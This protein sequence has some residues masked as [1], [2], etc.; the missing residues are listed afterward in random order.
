[1]MW[2][3]ASYWLIKAGKQ[4]SITLDETGRS[5]L[6]DC[7]YIVHMGHVTSKQV[8]TTCELAVTLNK[9]WRYNKVNLATLPPYAYMVLVG[10][11]QE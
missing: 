6:L 9:F 3:N 7:N 2:R 10:Y 11:D 1:M 4:V 8:L 5:G